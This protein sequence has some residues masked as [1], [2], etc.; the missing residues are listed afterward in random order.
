MNHISLRMLRTFVTVAEKGT[1]AAAAEKLA[2]SSGSVSTTISEFEE[3]VG[4]QLFVRKPAKG[5]SLTAA[6]EVIAL[7]ARGLL[8]HA[9]EF[10]TIAGAL[11]SAIEGDLAVGC[12]INLAPVVFASL[13]AQFSATYPGIRLQ[14]VLG[15]QEEILQSL[16]NGRIETALTFDLAL[17]DQFQAARMVELPP[18]VLLPS[19][20]PLA[21]RATIDLAALASEPLVLMDLPHTREYFLSIFHALGIEPN[22]KFRS[23]S[24]EAVRTMVGNGLG[25][26]VLT[27]KPMISMTYDGTEVVNV[28]LEDRT[29]TLN[30]VLLTLKKIAR[31]RIVLTFQDFVRG[32]LKNWHADQSRMKLI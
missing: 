3:L 24:Y 27:L 23:S 11:G 9:D 19:F 31:R 6:G 21:K 5:L 13:V 14:I 18:Y 32:Y 4:V 7:E 10:E 29:R 1:V 20:H 26:S 2:R 28:P 8:L 16:K 25:Y 22:I 15:D 30:I 12:F 17:S